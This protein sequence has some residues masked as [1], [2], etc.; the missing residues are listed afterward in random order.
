VKELEDVLNEAV[1]EER[2]P[3]HDSPEIRASISRQM[4]VLRHLDSKRSIFDK[5]K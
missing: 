1:K 2:L 4:A 5:V 3:V